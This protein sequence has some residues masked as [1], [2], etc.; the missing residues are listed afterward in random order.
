MDE[1][2]PPLLRM[3]RISKSFGAT[4]ALDQVDFDLR[5]GEAHALLGENGAGKSTLIK[6]LS[7]AIK[8]DGGAIWL[9]GRRFA[10]A[11]PLE[12]RRAGISV[13]YQELNLAPHLTVEDNIMLGRE[14]HGFG[15]LRRRRMREKV[16]EALGQV[17]HAEI[18]P[19]VP[20]RQLSVAARQVVEIARALA[21][22]AK[23]LVMDEPTSSLSGEDSQRLFGIIR[24]LKSQGVGIVYISHFLEEVR[25]VA[26]R[27][28]VLRDGKKAGSGR[29]EELSLENIIKMMVGGE[30]KEL[31][32][33]VAHQA[34]EEVLESG[35]LKGKKMPAAVTLALRRGEILGIA[36]LV[37]SGRTEFLRTLFGLDFMESGR[38]HIGGEEV[39]RGGPRQRIRNGIGLLSEDRQG[40]GLAL[41]RSIADNLTLSHFAPYVRW[42]FLRN[43]KQKQA[44]ED[45][46]AK[47]QIKARNPG[48]PVSSLSGGN[49]QK[50][51]LARLLHQNAAVFL[52]DEPTRGI[53]I[54]SK[55]QIYESMGD[56]ALQ[57]KSILFVSSYF[58]ELLGVCDRIAVFHRGR[59]IDLRPA[60]E[61]DEEALLAAATT[62]RPATR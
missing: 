43:K 45:W 52:L 60:V 36:G 40:E 57:G 2:R 42:S 55:S 58:P 9:E 23:I 51:A 44:A 61:W 14:W 39:F 19:D 29:M 17:H 38:L 16:V 37:G 18:P 21:E 22:R 33:Q 47:M 56:L 8:P 34:G 24:R 12:S 50:V 46:I 20:V 35:G 41:S 28:T 49:Q 32:P 5:P 30:V 10:P 62:G 26:D 11:G 48:Q 25:Q 4:R 31:F 54:G 53:D 3:E 15:F 59:L 27:S 6:I 13:I 7:G 1:S